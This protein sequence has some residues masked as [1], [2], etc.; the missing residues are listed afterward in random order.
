M[1]GIAALAGA[2]FMAG[3]IGTADAPATRMADIIPEAASPAAASLRR[4]ILRAAV[5]RLR[6]IL[7]ADPAA[8][9]RAAARQASSIS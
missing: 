2:V 6:E 9:N 4:A 7:P 1:P 8:V 5:N 3:T